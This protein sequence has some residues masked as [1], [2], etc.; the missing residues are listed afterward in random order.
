MD[1]ATSMLARLLHTH[2]PPAHSRTSCTLAYLCT[3]TC[4]PL[5]QW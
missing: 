5:F 1:A 4:G 2:A 3:L